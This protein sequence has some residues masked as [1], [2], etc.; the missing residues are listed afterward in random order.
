MKDKEAETKM[1]KNE[2]M[3][4]RTSLNYLLQMKLK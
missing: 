1:S 2:N 3:E 4:L